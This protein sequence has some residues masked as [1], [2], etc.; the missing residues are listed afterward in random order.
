MVTFIINLLRKKYYCST[1]N[2]TDQGVSGRL[3]VNTPLASLFT[4]SFLVFHPLCLSIFVWL[5]LG[6]C[7]LPIF[8]HSAYEYPCS[9]SRVS[10][11]KDV[12]GFNPSRVRLILLA[13]A[14]IKLLR[15]AADGTFSSYS[16][17]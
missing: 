6:E 17:G 12:S 7:G 10:M 9:L 8:S 14:S 11:M 15:F 1:I 2:T 3:R 13:E 16:T 5:W 4:Y